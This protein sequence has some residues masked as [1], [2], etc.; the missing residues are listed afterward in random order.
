M[1]RSHE[2]QIQN[3]EA[4]SRRPKRRRD[5]EFGIQIGNFILHSRPPPLVTLHPPLSTRSP[6]N[7][8]AP[9]RFAQASRVLELDGAGDYVRLPPAGFTNFH[10]STIE[11]WVKWR[12]YGSSARVFDFGTRQREI[13]WESLQARLPPARPR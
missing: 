4:A 13:M 1:A 8:A 11:A 10:Q 9:E 6:A 3:R 2:Y 7:Q 5:V 12:S